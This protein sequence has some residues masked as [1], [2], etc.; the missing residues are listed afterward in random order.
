M[1]APVYTDANVKALCAGPPPGQRHGLPVPGS[2]RPNRTAAYRHW[3]F[4]DKPL[5]AGFDP[6]LKSVHDVFEKTVRRI[7][8]KR[9][10]GTRNWNTAARDWEDKFDWVTFS[11]AAERRKNLGAGLVEVHKLAGIEKDKHGVGLWSQNRLE[12]QLTGEYASETAD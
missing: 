1:A 7:P 10:F 3:R 5:L 6:D 9:A 11:E 8:N 4:V 2:E 12:W